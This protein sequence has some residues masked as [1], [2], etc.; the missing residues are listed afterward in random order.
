VR[1]LM[2]LLKARNRTELALIV[3]D[4]MRPKPGRSPFCG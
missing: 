3:V 2:K 1:S 4:Q